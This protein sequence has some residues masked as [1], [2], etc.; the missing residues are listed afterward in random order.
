MARKRGRQ[1][2]TKK[3]SPEWMTTYGDMV[4]L[5][6][7]FFILLFAFSEIDAKKFEAVIRSFQGSLGILDSGKTIEQSEYITSAMQDELTTNQLEELE[8]FR[9]LEERLRQFLEANELDA[10]VLITLETRGLVLR[11]QDNVLFDPGLAELKERSKEILSFIAEVLYEPEFE[12][13]FVRVEGHTDNV[14]M[15]SYRYPSNWELSVSRATNV[16]RHFIEELG[17]EPDKFSAAG[18][19]EYHPVAENDSAENKAKNR[20]VDIVILK[21]ELTISTP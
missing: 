6:L 11:F 10:D 21:S 18:Y 4:T 14:P 3:G 17:L 7:C 2:E 8:D 1:E 16:V 13:K 9:K 19:G 20:R 5:L 15:S 12:K